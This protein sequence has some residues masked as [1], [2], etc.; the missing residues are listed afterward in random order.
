M[1]LLLRE[2]TT[3]IDTARKRGAKG[4]EALL[5][6]E[7]RSSLEVRRGTA[8]KKIENAQSSHIM[9]RCWLE[10]GCTGSAT[11]AIDD[12]LSLLEQA[13]KAASTASPDP[14]EG[15]VGRLGS[16]SRGLGIDDRRYPQISMADRADVLQSA[17]RGARN[18]DRRAQTSG[19]TYEDK[20]V[21]RCFVNSKGSILEE[22]STLYRTT[23][24]VSVSDGEH[25]IT[26]DNTIESRTFSS[27]ASLPFGANLTRRGVELLQPGPDLSGAVRVVFP[28]H[29]TAS[30][31]H[32]AVTPITIGKCKSAK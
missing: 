11:G 15:P 30:H 25:T 3:L 16:S 32:P 23:G 20:R 28:P 24:T 27:I 7:A 6:E 22:F 19:F 17:E 26:L 29:V 5:Y 9:V 1:G 12:R 2:L 31:K 4:T 13:L 18:A 14:H 21:R 10:G 8:S